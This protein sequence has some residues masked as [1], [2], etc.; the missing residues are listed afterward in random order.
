MSEFLF[1]KIQRESLRASKLLLLPVFFSGLCLSCYAQARPGDYSVL[2]GNWHAV[3]AASASLSGGIDFT[4]GTY[5]NAVRGVGQFPVS[6]ARENGAAV[7]RSEPKLVEGQVHPDGR[8]QLRAPDGTLISGAIPAGSADKWM[9]NLRVSDVAGNSPTAGQCRA[10]SASF[11]AKRVPLLDG[12][13]TGTI[14][15][16]QIA[17]LNPD[18]GRPQDAE[19]QVSLKVVQGKLFATGM[20][21]DFAYV[22]PLNAKISLTGSSKFPS[23]SFET[24]QRSSVKN[25]FGWGSGI[26]EFLG[27]DDG[28]RM[29]AYISKKSA[30]D[31]RIWIVL[32]YTGN[33]Q[34]GKHVGIV[35]VGW[36]TRQR[37]PPID[38]VAAQMGGG[39]ELGAQ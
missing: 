14:G 13:Y 15:L 6:C 16:D 25:R 34:S 27:N 21:G 28:T 36:L 35:G 2:N 32:G 33:D 20:R 7:M 23:G 9:G 11:E 29:T 19:A 30:D 17:R 31:D 10:A 8:F 38:V 5:G 37:L 39:R 22:I 1:G 12:I 24:E 26:M 3:V 4:L 18:P